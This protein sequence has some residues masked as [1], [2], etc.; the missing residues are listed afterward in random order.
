MQRF[1]TENVFHNAGEATASICRC[2]VEIRPE[3]SLEAFLRPIVLSIRDEILENGAGKSGRI[4]TTEVL[5]RDRTLLWHLRIFF[6]LIGPRTG[7]AVL[8]YLNGPNS[9]IRDVINLTVRECKGTMYYYLGKSLINV[10]S[11]LTG[12]VYP[13]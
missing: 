7:S 6:A 3:E 10:I 2:F 8:K 1:I 13:W 12:N 9:L 5:P 11:S 4:T